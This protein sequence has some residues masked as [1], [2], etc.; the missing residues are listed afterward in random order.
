MNWITES[1]RKVMAN[2]SVNLTTVPKI[3]KKISKWILLWRNPVNTQDKGTIFYVSTRA[4]IRLNKLIFT[5]MW[6]AKSAWKI[7]TSPSAARPIKILL[8]CFQNRKITSHWLG[9]LHADQKTSRE[10]Q[11]ALLTN[12]ANIF[13]SPCTPAISSH[14]VTLKHSAS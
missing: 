5:T 6:N 1:R 9:M 3:F 14:P 13:N 8:N 10:T 4:T 11:T 2:W 12:P 7:A